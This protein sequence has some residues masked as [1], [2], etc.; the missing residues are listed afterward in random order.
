[1]IAKLVAVGDD[2]DEAIGELAAMLDGVEVWPVRTNAGFL[3]NAVLERG[4]RSGARSIPASS[5]G[6][7][8][9]W[10][11]MPSPTMRSGALRHLVAIR[12]ARR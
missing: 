4:F 12:A 1:M 10:C 2:R 9:S 5:N 7:S 8:M 11:P 6:T 3:F